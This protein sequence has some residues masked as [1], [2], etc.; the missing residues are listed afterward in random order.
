[1]NIQMFSKCVGV[2]PYTIRYYE[3][4]GLLKVYRKKNGHRDFSENDIRWMEFIL[5]LKVTGMPLS[6]IQQYARLR[7]QGNSTLKA[8][9]SMLILHQK[10]L[11]QRLDE[12]QQNAALLAEKINFYDD[13][14]RHLSIEKDN[15]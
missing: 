1:M 2:T 10:E 8:R 9:R 3:K 5:R 13:E 11:S 4:V 6:Q 14:I 7:E 12:L 15:A